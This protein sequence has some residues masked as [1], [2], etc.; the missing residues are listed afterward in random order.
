MAQKRETRV[1]SGVYLVSLVC[2]VESDQPVSL[3]SLFSPV[4][5]NLAFHW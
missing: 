3:V 2:L 5:P 1:V 4:P